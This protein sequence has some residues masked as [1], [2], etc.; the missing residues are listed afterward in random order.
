[1]ARAG[2]GGTWVPVLLFLHIPL[3][4][5]RE[6][7][8]DEAEKRILGDFKEKVW[9]SG[10]NGGLYAAALDNG[11]V[12][13]VFVGHDHVNDFCHQNLFSN[14]TL[15]YCGVSGYGAYSRNGWARRVRL[16][17]YTM[18]DD[19][20]VLRTWKRLDGPALPIK[21]LQTLGMIPEDGEIYVSLTFE[22]WMAISAVSGALGSM[23]LLLLLQALLRFRLRQ[24]KIPA[25]KEL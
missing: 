16:I 2:K 4:E 7:L 23:V 10:I 13:G 17:E 1:M 22:A 6:L 3:P 5:V 11:R 14:I 8:N 9:H 25:V 24:K 15:C 12:R 18:V 20:P 19:E 21:D